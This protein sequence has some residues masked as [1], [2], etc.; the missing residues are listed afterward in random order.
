MLMGAAV[1]HTARRLAE[2][3]RGAFQPDGLSLW[4]SNGAAAGQ[5]VPHFHL[6]LMPSW[7]GDQ[8]LRIYPGRVEA[9][10]P[11]ELDR[12]AGAIRSALVSG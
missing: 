9:V 7:Q 4:K 12:Q 3:V 2:A 11:G 6:H 8:L 1:K 10:E 5:E